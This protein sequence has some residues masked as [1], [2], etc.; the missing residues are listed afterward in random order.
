MRIALVFMFPVGTKHSLLIT[1]KCSG[2]TAMPSMFALDGFA[3]ISKYEFF[4]RIC[5]KQVE[6]DFASNWESF[7]P[8]QINENLGDGAS[9]RR[10]ISCNI[11][12]VR[13]EIS[14]KCTAI[15]NVLSGES[16]AKEL[17][18]PNNLDTQTVENIAI[19]VVAFPANDNLSVQNTEEPRVAVTSR[20]FESFRTLEDQTL[21]IW[22][23]F[24]QNVAVHDDHVDTGVFEYVEISFKTANGDIT[25]LS[26]S[27]YVQ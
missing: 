5:R 11:Q 6:G 9:C 1:T 20:G 3:E 2:C 25:D 15:K 22:N 8:F 19:T 13:H 18:M 14:D 10:R 24:F 21:F 12:E 27:H 26:L 7:V 23:T 17:L 4:V 16:S